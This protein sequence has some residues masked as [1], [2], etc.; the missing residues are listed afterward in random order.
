MDIDLNEEYVLGLIDYL[1]RPSLQ[2]YPMSGS[3]GLDPKVHV[4]LRQSEII[5]GV[6]SQF[7]KSEG[8]EHRY[9][10]RG[11]EDVPERI[12]INKPEDI[13]NLRDLGQ[14]V[15]IQTAEALEYLVA[16]NREYGGKTIAGNE[17]RFY[18]LYKP[19]ADMHP[20]WSNKKYTLDFFEKEFDI[21]AVSDLFDA[22][23]PEYPDSITTGYVAGAFDASGM[24]SLSISKE[25][26]NNTGYGMNPFARI[27]IRHPDIRVK[28][29]FIRY[30]NSHDLEPNI[31]KNDNQL[32]IRFN[33]A[34]TVER[35]IEK[36]GENT[37]YL[38]ELCE[39]FYRQLIP[40]YNDQYHTTKKG[41]LDIVRAFE[42]VAPKR[43]R[44]QYTTGFFEEEWELES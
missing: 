42:E 16:V 20:H 4:S 6:V 21:E 34:D 41:F 31:S 43:P 18:Q 24:I 23:D 11:S 19:W 22:P 38:Y 8:I 3:Y 9:K 25:P 39:L 44:A 13:H 32:R 5:L 29:N 26:V 1:S 27:T 35:F 40:A 37:I 2:P 12:L 10:R 7:L 33:S 28:P 15:F 30:F 36:V 14:G 17:E